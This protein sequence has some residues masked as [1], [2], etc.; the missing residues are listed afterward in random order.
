MFFKYAFLAWPIVASIL[1]SPTTSIT[2]AQIPFGLAAATNLVLTALTGK[3][4]PSV[5]DFR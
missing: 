3:E 4:I 1:A 2:N 5:V